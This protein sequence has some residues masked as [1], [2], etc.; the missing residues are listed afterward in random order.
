MVQL[1]GNRDTMRQ[2]SV[3]SALDLLRRALRTM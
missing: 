3:I 1:L 2:L